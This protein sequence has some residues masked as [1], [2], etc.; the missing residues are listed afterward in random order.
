MMLGKFTCMVAEVGAVLLLDGGS[1]SHGIDRS[2]LCQL[3][4]PKLGDHYEV[5]VKQFDGLHQ[6]TECIGW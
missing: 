3:W 6:P 4:R 1:R 2:R 5:A